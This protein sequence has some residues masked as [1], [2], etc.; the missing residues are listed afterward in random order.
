MEEVI[1]GLNKWVKNDLI[2]EE[3][4]PLALY[5]RRF[6][7]ISFQIHEITKTTIKILVYQGESKQ[8]PYADE[9]LLKQRAYELFWKFFHKLKFDIV[10]IPYHPHM[11]CPE[12]WGQR[13]KQQ[14]VIGMASEEIN[15]LLLKSARTLYPSI[16]FPWVKYTHEWST[17][18]LVTRLIMEDYPQVSEEF[19]PPLY[20]YI[21]FYLDYKD[22]Q[23]KTANMTKTPLAWQI[24]ELTDYNIIE[25][26]NCKVSELWDMVDFAGD[27]ENSSLALYVCTEGRAL[28]E[29]LCDDIISRYKGLK[30]EREYLIDT[31]RNIIPSGDPLREFADEE[32]H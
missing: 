23:L 1:K 24:K 8:K 32:S 5:Y 12:K 2:K 6:A 28:R 3:I 4:E 31:I 13:D 18:L 27:R 17:V 21:Y 7:N 14:A 26:V 30:Y 16:C 19:L 9:K 20:Q 11:L 25:L 15:D 22:G 10:A 29:K